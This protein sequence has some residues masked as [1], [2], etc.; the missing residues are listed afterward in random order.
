M[1]VKQEAYELVGEFDAKTF[2]RGYG[3][4]NDFCCRCSM[5]GYTHVLCDDTFIYHAGTASFASEEK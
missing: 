4:E 1:Y 2:G 5:L 3:E